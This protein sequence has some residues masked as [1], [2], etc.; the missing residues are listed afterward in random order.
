MTRSAPYFSDET[1][2]FL[3]ALAKNNSREWFAVNKPRYEQHVRGPCLR[4]ITDLADPLRN[5]SPQLTAIAKPVGGSLFRIHR[6]TR[7]SGDKRPYKTHAGLYFA[8]AAAK[9]AAR[10]DAGIAALG[11]LDAPGLYL[12]LEPDACFLGGGIWHPQPPTVKRVRDYMLANP[13]SWKQAT[14][15]PQFR[16]TFEM[17]GDALSRPPRGYDPGHAL[18]DDLKRKDFVASAPLDD[19]ELLRPDLVERLT[20]RYRQLAPMLDWLCGA[21]D[22][23]F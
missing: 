1:F 20:R 13:V 5:I 9:A 8:H 10:G 17:G 4:L 23:E 14:R 6:D 3:R 16:R 2:R 7:F 15:S 12:H 19:A 21:L 11:R 22:L 18:I